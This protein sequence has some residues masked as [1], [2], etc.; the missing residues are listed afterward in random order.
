LHK[1]GKEAL[2][3]SIYIKEESIAHKNLAEELKKQGVVDFA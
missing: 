1:W 3:A 2:S